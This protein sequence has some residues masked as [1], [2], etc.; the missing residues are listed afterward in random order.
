MARAALDSLNPNS[1]SSQ[2]TSLSAA[3]EAAVR[4][5]EAASSGER[6]LVLLTDGEDQGDPA[7]LTES[8]DRAERNK[9]RVYTIGIGTTQGMPIPT[10]N[11]YKQDKDGKVVN[12]KLDFT[13]LTDIAQKTNGRAIKSNPKGASELDPIMADLEKLQRRDQQDRMYRVYKERYQWF[14]LPVILLLVL[15]ALEYGGSGR[16]RLQKGVQ[17]QVS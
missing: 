4:A 14:L 17:A 9:V 5:F 8:I 16:R 11:G 7:R 12:S 3:M 10:Q 15:E 6:V 2:G 13:K 1:V